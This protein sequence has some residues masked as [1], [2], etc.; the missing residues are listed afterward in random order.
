MEERGMARGEGVRG[1]LVALGNDL[2]QVWPEGAAGEGERREAEGI[3]PDL[4]VENS[5]AQT[6]SYRL[7]FPEF[8]FSIRF[9]SSFTFIRVSSSASPCTLHT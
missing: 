3:P 6:Y 2:M 5:I 9:P 4:Y 7:W 1:E 8:S